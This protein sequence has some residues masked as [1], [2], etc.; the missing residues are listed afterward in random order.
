MDRC[1]HSESRNNIRYTTFL[2]LGAP[3]IVYIDQIKIHNS[4][5][6]Y[7]KNFNDSASLIW[8]SQTRPRKRRVWC[9]LIVYVDLYPLQDF[10]SPMKSRIVDKSHDRF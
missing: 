10:C 3:E 1:E 8:Q 5:V 6:M 7:K 9:T 4:I 2:T